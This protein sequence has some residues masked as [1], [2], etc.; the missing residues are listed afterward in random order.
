MLRNPG[1]TQPS[2]LFLGAVVTGCILLLVL[3]AVSD[4]Q[5]PS[6]ITP[7]GTLGTIVTPE[8]RVFNIMGGT[9]PGQ[10]PNLF[11][12]FGHFDVGTGD[13]AHF[14]GQL[15]IENIIGRVTGGSESMIDGR[16]QSDASLF[17]LN[18]SGLMFGP[19]AILDV[20]GS[21]HASTADALR[22]A[23]GATFST[24]LNAKSTFTVDTPVAFG[25]LSENPSGIVIEGNVLEVPENDTVS[26][27]GGDIQIVGG[28]LKAP[29]GRVHLASLASS[30][31]VIP[32]LADQSPGL[33]V[34]TAERLGRIDLQDTRIDASGVGGGAVL[35]RGG[36]LLVDNATVLANTVGEID[37]VGLAVQVSGDVVLTNGSSLITETLDAGAAGL[38]RISAGNVLMDEAA[39]VVSSTRAA[40][41]AG[42]VMVD[43]P[44]V[45]LSGGAQIGSTTSGKGQGGKVTVRASE[46]VTLE[47]IAPDG[48][49][50]A[51]VAVTQ[52]QH[53]GAGDG[54]TVVVDASQVILT[55]RGQIASR[56][57]GKGQ[58]GTVIV[59]ATEAVILEAASAIVANAQGLGKA[60]GDAGTIVVKAPRV[61]LTGG[62]QLGSGTSGEG[63]G[64][65][66]TVRASEMVTL[67]G[68]APDGRP[69]A[70]VAN[71]KGAGD[72]G[73]VV[74]D[75]PQITLTG[76]AQ[77]VSGTS[78]EGQGGTV[79]VTATEAVILEAASGIFANVL[80]EEAAGNAG[81]VTVDAPQVT[82]SGGAQIGSTTSGKG[83]GG[84]VTV[85]ASEMVTLEGTAPDGRSSAIVAVTQG[86]HEGAGDGGTV[87]VDASQVILTGRGQI[88]SR[89]SGKGQGGTVIVTAT[90]AVILEAA[91]A[92]VANAQG[93]GKAAGDAGTIVVK[94]PRVTLTGGAQLVSTTSGKGQGGTVIVTATEAVILEAA[95]AISVNALGMDEAAG[96]AGTI[97]V[98]APRVTLTGG[99]QL[100]SGTSG[101]GQG[102]SVTVRASE[103][104]TLEGTVPY[105]RPSAIVANTKGAGDG[106]TV[107]VDAPQIT[108]TGGAQLV[109][110]TSGE[111]QGGTVIVTAT[112]A[113]ILE[114]ASAIV[115]NAQG[116]GKAAG[117]AGTI[118]VKAPRVT[119]TGGAQLVSGTSGK[120]QGGSVTVRASEM[121]T[122]EGTAPDGRSSAIVANTKGAGDG[123]TVVVDAPQITLTGGAQLGSGTS[124][125]GQGGNIILQASNLQLKGAK[126]STQSDGIGSAGTIR[127]NT[128]AVFLSNG[129]AIS[130]A[131]PLSDGGNI[132]ITSEGG[133]VHL[134][135]SQIT[136]LVEGGQ[137]G[138]VNID[139]EAL[140]L[141]QGGQIVTRAGA[142][143]GGNITIDGVFVSHGTFVQIQEVGQECPV[144]SACINPTG[145]VMSGTVETN[146]LDTSGTLR[147]LVAR[148][149]QAT[150]LLQKPCAERLLAATR[151]SMVVSGRA[152]MPARPEGVLPSPV[153]SANR[154]RIVTLKQD[155]PLAKTVASYPD[156]DGAPAKDMGQGWMSLHHGDFEE[157]VHHWQEVVR[158]LE[159]E[160]EAYQQ[161]EALVHLGQ[162]YQKLGHYQQ[163][164]QSLKSAQMLAEK[165]GDQV[166]KAF[167]LGELGNVH[168][169][170]GPVNQASQ[171]F[172]AGLR[173][174]REMK[175]D[176]LVATVLNNRG[177]LFASQEAFDEAFQSYKESA[178]LAKLTGNHALTARALTNAALITLR[179]GKPQEAQ[180]LLDQV[181]PVL[182]AL[183][184]SHE[185]AYGLV[186]I[187]LIYANLRSHLPAMDASHLPLALRSFNDAVAVAQAIGDARAASYAWGYLGKLY[188]GEGRYQEALALARRAVFAVQPVQ[189]P[190]ASYQWQWQSGR[191]LQALGQRKAAMAAYREAIHTLQAMRHEMRVAYGEPLRFREMVGPVYAEFV[192]LLLQ[193]G[194]AEDALEE[195]RQTL[196]FLKVAELQNYFEDE[197]VAALRL[198]ETSLDEVS[199]T[200]VVVY[201]VLLPNRTELLV[202]LPT[203]A[204][205]SKLQQ[206]TVPVGADRL[207][208]EVRALR[209]GL[210]N[211]TTQQYLRHAQRLYDWLIGP[212]EPALASLAVTTLVFVPDG[213]LWTIPMAALHDGERFL[214][215]K[216]A[217]A[218]TPGL[219]L[220]DPHP[221]PQPAR[222]L[223]AGLTQAVQGFSSLPYVGTELRAIAH[224][225]QSD[226][227]L[228]QDFQVSRLEKAL[229]KGLFPIVHIASHGRFS[230]DLDDTFILAFNDKL[231]L[232]RLDQLLGPLRFRDAPIELLALSACQT[233]AGDD[234]AAL[235]LAGVAVK[236][237]ARSALATLW[238]INDQA[239]SQLVAE[240][241]RHLRAPAVS[242]AMA[243]Q[244]AQIHLLDD[245]NY[246]HPAY[247]AP[248][249][250]INNW[251]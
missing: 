232:E 234:Q 136:T 85:R 152:G 139:S 206:F 27:V 41:N 235:G 179:R 32:A 65:S 186:S 13:R 221:L 207:T 76:G 213:A 156:A 103:M 119:L 101:E 44:Q 60:A 1:A 147:P 203:R 43:A 24:H 174:A 197:C 75:A 108:L 40:G 126:L 79:I 74:V 116:L 37:G 102:G 245:P 15:G 201:P 122:L 107:V 143:S 100:G 180:A 144:G 190:E 16:L 87:V 11:H 149:T 226:L 216:Y 215:Q 67:E 173:L 47:G 70:I 29:G 45:T 131:A 241:Y 57:S 71:T 46:R 53:E 90:E 154:N 77:L 169:P 218:I 212:L 158:V 84:K 62:A 121:V 134:M 159:R 104:V 98:K 189:A 95:S 166:L 96:D 25:F 170:L 117:D 80:E 167:I 120:G 162:A 55:G 178:R 125:E 9:R 64:G 86:Q 111:G 83:Q 148:F 237:G 233:A 141:D 168:I 209:Q 181:F 225:Y 137:G 200:A 33:T 69:S 5:V 146:P 68:T 21:F 58:G 8:G 161:S 93:L 172:Q 230:S 183:S 92:I 151:S 89:T 73:T 12:S 112:E 155:E 157:A 250:L 246:Q 10:G 91:S 17:L 34:D 244:R 110:G 132:T 204:G 14:V 223:A 177:N 42:K 227:L 220:T 182:Q 222:V 61:T 22:F 231:T 165:S 228:N 238:Y 135:D 243:L 217:L 7:D 129:A 99:A 72:G 106:G 113:V 23:D 194:A 140:V 198:Q 195:A 176:D 187:G 6:A 3:R 188:E 142:G 127:I 105:G 19:N 192:G 48:R 54:G 191:V 153:F 81:N 145:M 128:D 82:L 38:I 211:R 196:E 124:G 164:L 251:L 199:Q 224:L 88:A 210:E 171:Y 30:G 175:A 193:P 97:V 52:G 50:S 115:A 150:E 31:E 184:P 56:T 118:V 185:K 247:W 133:I 39:K 202:S 214:I 248:F 28:T 78:G 239:S 163:A 59:T 242:R 160:A 123:G 35:I 63:Q 66:V 208:Q 114:A 240:F 4:A 109:S 49:S 229:D 51:I 249:L 138:N 26:V 205:V 36:H 2:R 236:A 18:P 20:K 219:N 130:A 94:A